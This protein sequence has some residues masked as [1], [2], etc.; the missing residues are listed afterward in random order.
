MPS[1][2]PKNC[3]EFMGCDKKARGKCPAYTTD[4]G[5]ECWFV[6]SHYK[7]GGC[8]KAKGDYRNCFECP[9]FRKLNPSYAAN[10]TEIQQRVE[11]RLKAEGVI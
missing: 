2:S 3:W 6:A 8:P 11:A 1:K 10:K 7:A 9:W 4:S 5:K